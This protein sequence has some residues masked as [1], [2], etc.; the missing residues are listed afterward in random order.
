MTVGLRFELKKS[1]PPVSD[2]EYKDLKR[3]L[4]QAR[5]K[6]AQ[7][8]VYWDCDKDESRSEVRKKLLYVAAHENIPLTIQS[9]RKRSALRLTFKVKQK[10]LGADQ[11]REQILD[12]LRR[13]DVPL[14]RKEVLELTEVTP[15]SWSLSI[16]KLLM[17]G[18]VKR[19]GTKPQ[20]KY[21]AVV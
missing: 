18:L 10:R 19:V 16:K 12:A 17:E 2:T 9:L 8:H 14:S 5:E 6:A 21:D 11:A 15:T 20:T 1:K 3:L 4:H 7:H 13:S